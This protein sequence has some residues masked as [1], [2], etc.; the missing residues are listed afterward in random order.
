MKAVMAQAISMSQAV[1]IKEISLKKGRFMLCLKN[2]Q[3]NHTE[4]L[5][6]LTIRK[7]GAFSTNFLA[8]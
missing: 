3:R 2:R 7:A 4:G 1:I 6:Y 8:S 5:N